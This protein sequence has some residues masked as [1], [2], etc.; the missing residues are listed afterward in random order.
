MRVMATRMMNGIGRLNV[1]IRPDE[2][3]ACRFDAAN[4]QP[5]RA[6]AHQQRRQAQQSSEM[7]E[8]VQLTDL[9]HVPASAGWACGTARLDR[10]PIIMRSLRKVKN[11]C[12]LL[13]EPS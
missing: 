2:S 13:V 4:M 3:I 5:P 1:R 12:S 10:W 7:A 9:L 11:E 8:N 6:V